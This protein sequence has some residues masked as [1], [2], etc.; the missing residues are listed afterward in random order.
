MAQAKEESYLQPTPEAQPFWDAIRRHELMLPRCRACGQ[1]LY[2]SKNFCPKCLSRDLEWVRCA[3]RGRVYSYVIHHRPTQG[4]ADEVSEITAVVE[5]EEGPRIMGPMTAIGPDH[6]WL[7]VNIPVEILFQG[8]AKGSIKLMFR[9]AGP[10][11]F[12]VDEE[13]PG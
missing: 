11:F 2:Y 6:R 7:R 3:G 5:L 10:E 9:P 4:F 1:F 13:R 8:V 12:P